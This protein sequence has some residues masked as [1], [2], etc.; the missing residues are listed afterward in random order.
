[1]AKILEYAKHL[2]LIPIV[3]FLLSALMT[4][5]WGALKV[6]NLI[7]SILSMSME[8]SQ[9]FLALLEMLDTF[10]IGTVLFIFAIGYYDLFIGKV[11][12]PAWLVIDDLGKLKT[13]LSDVIVMFMAV[14]FLD[15]LLQ[16]TNALDTLFYAIGIA[17][18]ALTLIALNRSR[19]ET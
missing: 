12:T 4:F 9:V 11:N 5:L 14:K 1:M 2:N 10:L 13:K 8:S 7:I 3:A 18:V 16:S 19:A 6:F 17:V 15:K